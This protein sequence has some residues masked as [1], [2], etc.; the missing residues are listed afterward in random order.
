[1]KTQ[2]T[3]QKAQSLLEDYLFKYSEIGIKDA[4]KDEIYKALSRIAHDILLEKREK[5]HSKVAKSGAKRVHYLCMEF[6][7]G[8]NLKSTLFNLKMDEV[9]AQVL[10]SFNIDID[11]IYEVECDA[12]LGNGGLGRLAA[13]FMDSFATLNLPSM[14]HSILYEYGLFKQK[15]VDGEQ[16]ELTDSWRHTGD[17]WLQ[18]RTSKSVI[19]KFGGSVKENMVNGRLIPEYSG[20]TEVQAIPYDMILSGYDSEGVSVLRLWEAKSINQF[21]LNSFSQGAYVQAVADASKIEMI[22]KVL[23]PADDHT[24]GKTL[25][26]EQQ[27]FLVSAALQ[28]IVN[29]HIKRYK[30]LSTLPDMIALHI[31][32]THPALSIPELMRILMDDHGYSWDHAWDVVTKTIGYTNHTVLMEALEKWDENLFKTTLPRIYQIVK[33]INRR[34]TKDLFDNHQDEFDLQT[35]EKMSII[36]GGQVR[37]ANLSVVASHKVNGVSRLHSE[38]IRTDLFK[39]FATLYEDKFTNVTNGIAHRRWL[40]QSNKALDDL[41][42]NTIGSNFYLKPNELEKFL[43]YENDKNVL[44]KLAKIK[45]KNKEEFAKYLKKTQGVEIDPSFRF[46][47]HVKR[48]HEYKRQLLNVLKIIHLYSQLLENPDLDVTPQVFFFGGKS[49]P[50]YYMAKR[51]IKLICKLSQEIDKNPQV[52]AK[53]KVVFL[54]NYN[55]SLAERIIPATDVSEQISLAGKEASGTGNMKFMIN[56]ALTLGTYDGANVEMCDCVG[57]DNIF[58][59]GLSSDEVDIEWKKGYNPKA[60]YE[61]NKKIH[62]IIE[63]LKVG[64]DGESFKDIANYLIEGQRPD[65]YMCLIDLESYIAKHEE[66]DKVYRNP[67]EWNRMCLVNIAKA[68]FFAADRSIKDYANNIWDLKPVK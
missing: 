62:N 56:G 35:I 30:K 55:V 22:S 61:S 15:I 11:D 26:L 40:S 9:F 14:G 50:K 21:D 23:Y 67:I 12:G 66:M 16:I 7:L 24:E 8:R 37:M 27:Y 5:F 63:M 6:L 2:L 18:R 59:F 36:S 31:N 32:D 39:N 33:E 20:Y 68:G 46:D 42:C 64:F 52:S 13:C 17:I 19:V 3:P 4:K 44:G 34:F 65:P 47:V 49:A 25:R 53:L 29:T 57:D 58:I 38:I 43:K 10:K 51:I 48:I 60:L 45:Q 28:N 54:E 41:L 1:M